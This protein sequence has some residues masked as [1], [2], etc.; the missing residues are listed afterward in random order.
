MEAVKGSF[1]VFPLITQAEED[2]A[3]PISGQGWN[4]DAPEDVR[5]VG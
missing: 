2:V 1:F 3:G 5:A 4:L